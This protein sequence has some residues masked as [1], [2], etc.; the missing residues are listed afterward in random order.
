[1]TSP[2]KDL[3]PDPV[4]ELATIP[5]TIALRHNSLLGVGRSRLALIGISSAIILAS[6]VVAI[7]YDHT[8]RQPAVIAL[9]TE[10][11]PQTPKLESQFELD[12]KL[13][14]EYDL[15]RQYLINYLTY[16]IGAL[17]GQNRDRIWDI[18][19]TEPLEL[20]VL[21]FKGIVFHDFPQKKAS[22]QVPTGK[23]DGEAQIKAWYY[24][25]DI[26]KQEEGERQQLF[27]WEENLKT[28]EVDIWSVRFDDKGGWPWNHEK[29]RPEFYRVGSS[30]GHGSW[31]LAN[32]FV[33]FKNTQGV[34][35]DSGYEV[36]L[37]RTVVSRVKGSDFFTR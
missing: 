28:R 16:D 12:P 24:G 18:V 7:G 10:S 21:D 17:F 1:M 36:F 15:T 30:V 22:R 19:I 25:D 20:E 27:V 23:P 13:Q 37:N 14:A 3:H 33:S 6:G 29:M 2:E 35:F 32:W 4:A 11:D 5:P 31:Y 9:T 8:L 34:Y 26:T